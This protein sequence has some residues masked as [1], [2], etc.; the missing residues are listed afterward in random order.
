MTTPSVSHAPRHRSA[1]LDT[2]RP[3]CVHLLISIDQP[4]FE[5]P[6]VGWYLR[7]LSILG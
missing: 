2:G 7:R 5:F 4:L 6:Q 1:S 3:S